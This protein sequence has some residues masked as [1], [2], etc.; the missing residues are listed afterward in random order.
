MGY[1]F[2]R[3]RLDRL[4]HG[5][6]VEGRSIRENRHN[7][8]IRRALVLFRL[9][10]PQNLGVCR[11]RGKQKSTNGGT[12][13]GGWKPGSAAS[14]VNLQGGHGGERSRVIEVRRV[15]VAEPTEAHEALDRAGRQGHAV[16][17]KGRTPSG[18][19]PFTRGLTL[20]PQSMG[21]RSEREPPASG[22][23]PPGVDYRH[24]GVDFAAAQRSHN[25]L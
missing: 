11:V 12:V 13:G 8:Q 2:I 20:L 7:R 24:P 23:T 1:G 4:C 18:Q 16:Q 10:C 6:V 5:R 17:K 25:T 3:F 21:D 19:P 9:A 14:R 15:T 22:T